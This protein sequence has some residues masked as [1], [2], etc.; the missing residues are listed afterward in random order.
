MS[1]IPSAIAALGPGALL[2]AETIPNEQAL[3]LGPTLGWLVF[4]CA[5]LVMAIA[6]L[7][8]ERVRAF[9]LRTEDPRSLGAFRIVFALV[10][11][12]NINNM[13]AHFEFLFTD[14]GLYLGDSA[15]QYGAGRQFWGYGLGGEGEAA[16]FFDLSAVLWWAKGPRYSLLHFWDSPGFFW[17]YIAVFEIATIAFLLGFRTR[18]MGFLS[19]ILTLGLM[20][21]SPIYQ[22]GAD[23]VFR[24]MFVYLVLSR[25]GHAYSIDNWLRCRKLRR[26]GRLSERDGPG[27]GAGAIVSDDEG[28]DSEQPREL[29]AIYRRIPA[30]PRMLILLQLVTIYLWTG[31]AKTG[32]VWSKGDSLYYALNLDHFSRVPTQYFG[33][34]FGTNLF[35]MMTWTVHFWQMGF[36]LM[37]LGLIVRWARREGLERPEQ[38]WRRWALRACWLGLAL[39]ALAITWVGLPVH[40]PPDAKLSLGALRGLVAGGWLVFITLFALGWRR[41]RD[42]PVVL[43]LRGHEWTLDLE[44]FCTV[45]LG[46][47][48]WLTLGLFFHLHIL[49]LMNIGMFAPVMIAVYIACLNGTEVAVILR[50]LGMA[51]ARLGVP[52]MAEWV[53]RGEAITPTESLEFIREREAKGLR[54]VSQ[55]LVGARL[56]PVGVLVA[57]FAGVVAGVLARVEDVSWWAWPLV[58]GVAL[59]TAYALGGRLV[60]GREGT[61]SSDSGDAKDGWVYAYG[62]FGR[63]VVM[64][65]VAVHLACV[66]AWSIPDKDCTRS[67]RAPAR[68]VVKPWMY[69]TQTHQSWNMFAPNPTRS[70][71]F[72]K[73]FVTDAEGELWDLYTDANSPR[74]KIQPWFIYDRMGKI[75]RRV[76]GKGK[77]YQKWVARYHCRMWALE[78]DG[79]VPEEVM[80]MKQWYRVPSP[81]TMRKRGPYQP[82]DYLAKHGHQKEVY[83]AKCATEPDAQP[84]NELRRRHGLPEVDEATIHRATKRRRP[85]WDSRQ[86]VESKVRKGRAKATKALRQ[87]KREAQRHAWQ[88]LGAQPPQR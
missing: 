40:I 22:S 58:L 13:W 46:R 49:V 14:E 25:C 36:G 78:H 71:V 5:L 16:G 1:G 84:T 75:T 88:T 69:R 17:G 61:K 82:E 37:V 41:L 9:W 30:W 8:V 56:L 62:A 45:F 65:F 35:R 51:L 86:G 12:L 59:P 73:V 54:R 48:L 24:V 29:E 77:H 53:V 15:R 52:G 32:S 39:L 19:L 47:K 87:A 42:R 43:R 80:I 55:P 20:N 60:G 28:K 21:R 23:V 7:D 44:S 83:T 3:A 27:E 2:A 70:N 68:E 31:C 10:L 18:A 34:V 76:T 67:F 66:A 63:G 85:R 81:E 6:V 74:N 26:A 4:A 79:E 50:R 57:S 33:Y 72:M 64:T 11:L 38:P